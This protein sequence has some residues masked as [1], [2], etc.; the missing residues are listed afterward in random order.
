MESSPLKTVDVDDKLEMLVTDFYTRVRHRVNNTTV[1]PTL[2]L[3][4]VLNATDMLLTL[5]KSSRELLQ[6]K[7]KR[8][9]SNCD[10]RLFDWL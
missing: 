10:I 9:E 4:C 1:S 7:M 3:P 2:I 5:H 6:L 8:F